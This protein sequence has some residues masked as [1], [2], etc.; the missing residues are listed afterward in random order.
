MTTEN[1]PKDNRTALW[2][3][4]LLCIVF[5]V[6]GLAFPEHVQ[7][8]LKMVSGTALEFTGDFIV[9]GC[10]LLLLLFIAL[11]ILP[12]GKR[13]LGQDEPE[14][15]TLAWL[16]MLFAAG[17]GTGLVAWAVAEPLT[18]L[19]SP[20][21]L[22]GDVARQA[23]L[24]THYH[25]GLHA[26]AIYGMGALVLAHFAFNKQVRTLPSSP[27]E[28]AFSGRW[29]RPTGRV[30]DNLAIIAVAFGVAGSMAMGTMQVHAG[31]TWLF[32]VPAQSMGVDVAILIALFF[33][34]MASSATGL[35]KGI[36][37]LSY[38]N[39]VAA[40]LL[41][42]LAMSMVGMT[43]VVFSF[44]QNMTDYLL[45]IPRL[46]LDPNPFDA[47]QGWRNGWTL[48]YLVWWV[49]W[50]PFVG[51]F[52]ARIS[53][54][55]S[56]RQ[57]VGGVLMV[58]SVFTVLWFSTFGDLGFMA[59]TAD[60]DGMR[61]AMD[62]DVLSALF[63]TFEYSASPTALVALTTVL[64]STFL[65]TSVD[66][67]TY[68]LAMLAEGGTLTPSNRTKYIW[69][70]TL[71]VMGAAFALSGTVESVKVML[72]TGGLPFLVVLGLQVVGYLRDIR[73]RD[74]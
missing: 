16:S 34:Y 39:M 35:D 44:A 64:A 26:W 30:A 63:V 58:P 17:M 23:M 29:V 74:P 20:P 7:R 65:V 43:Q 72:L 22:T 46:L 27:I 71:A 60:P 33:A 62:K 8:A 69:G 38:L 55:R 25:W 50:T 37:I 32:E 2:P 36:K 13:R 52:I 19:F 41:M 57:F 49:A 21:G 31:M 15:S 56:I 9:W 6:V 40:V 45:A 70:V 61:A 66:S 42:M 4:L 18:H 11:A 73:S 1:S 51:I 5:S 14:F 3:P 10:S 12:T 59:N 53:R 48:I 67:A 68:V 24:I 54:G 28:A 47:D